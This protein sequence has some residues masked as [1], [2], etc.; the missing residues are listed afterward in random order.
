MTQAVYEILWVLKL[1]E[2]V[3][4]KN[5]LPAKLWCNNQAAIHIASNLVFHEQTKYMLIDLH[6]IREKVQQKI[7]STRHIKT[8][9]Q[10]SDIFTKILNK[11]WG[12]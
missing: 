4:F 2:E 9:E 1:L 8:R 10:L 12:D 5:L 6:F 3:D 11:T 7:N